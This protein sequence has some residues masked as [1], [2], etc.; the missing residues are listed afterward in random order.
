MFISRVSVC[1][2]LRSSQVHMS[3]KYS[4]ISAILFLCLLEDNIYYLQ[5]CS[6][7]ICMCACSMPTYF[8]VCLS[9]SVCTSFSWH[10][11]FFISPVLVSISRYIFTLAGLYMC[12]CPVICMS[13]SPHFFNCV[14]GCYSSMAACL[15]IC[16]SVYPYVSHMFI[17]CLWS[18]RLHIFRKRFLLTILTFWSKKKG[19]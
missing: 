6:M 10:P 5:V 1:C 17:S 4:I 16:L 3:V 14:Y 8:Y 9:R 18:K 2:D 11:Y 19:S 15:F 7:I 13:V 12:T